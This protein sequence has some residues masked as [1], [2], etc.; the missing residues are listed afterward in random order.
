M[1]TEAVVSQEVLVRWLSQE[2]CIQAGANNMDMIL[3]YVE[4]V[5]KWLAEGKVVEPELLHL[6]WE[7]GNY[8]GKRIGVHASL[9]RSEEMKVA[10]V[11]GIP[12]NPM[13]PINYQTPRSNGMIILY[14]E[15]TGYPFAVMDDTIVSALRTGASSALGAK[16]C[17]RPDSESIGLV[18]C[19]VIQNAHIEATSKVMKHI[20]TVRLYDINKDKAKQFASK[21]EHLGYKFEIC[22]EIEKAVAPSDIVYTATNVNL[23]NEYIPK[24]WIKK[25]SFHSG[26]SMWDHKNEA[27][28]EGFNK[29]CMDY[30]LRLKDDKYP[31]SELTKA[32][33]LDA[34]AITELGQVILNKQVCRE[35]ED[36]TVF[37][38]TLGIC[39]TDTANSY[40]IY[41]NAKEKELGTNVKLWSKPAMF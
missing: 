4:K 19:G 3:E 15:D 18:G 20:K 26:V 39:A 22:D 24:E 36:D 27:I 40:R 41:K 34:E 1:S 38:V 29:Y 17:A 33:R 10:A 35:D 32:G 37:F 8:S 30:K 23:G 6:L 12:S 9:I 28:L 16:Y 25:G 7:E 13:N 2:E 14:N 31:L 11:K 21:W 5:N